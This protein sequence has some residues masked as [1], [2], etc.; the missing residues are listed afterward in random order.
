MRKV[1][2]RGT[3]T[4]TVQK[5][6]LFPVQSSVEATASQTPS[7]VQRDLETPTVHVTRIQEL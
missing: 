2:G 1:P 6:K 5:E 3:V 7:T 4:D